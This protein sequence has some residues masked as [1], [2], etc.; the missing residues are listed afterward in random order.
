[1]DSMAGE[2]VDRLIISGVEPVLT[3]RVGDGVLVRVAFAAKLDR[4][5]NQ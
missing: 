1:M 3:H 2:A 4:I 5:G